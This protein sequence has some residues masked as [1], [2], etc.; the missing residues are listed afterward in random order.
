MVSGNDVVLAVEQGQIAPG[1]RQH[2]VFYQG[3]VYLFSSEAT[4]QKF[5][6]NPAAYNANQSLEALRSGAIPGQPL[7]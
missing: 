2:G 1:M 3:R 4:L 5:S 6:A 7:R